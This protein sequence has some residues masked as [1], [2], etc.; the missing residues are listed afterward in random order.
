MKY[1]EILNKTKQFYA[2][3]VTIEIQIEVVRETTG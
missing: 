1:T 2:S 3:N